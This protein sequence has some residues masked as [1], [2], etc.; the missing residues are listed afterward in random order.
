[1]NRFDR[2]LGILLYLR[3]GRM[4][5]AG[6][7][8]TR[9]E[10]SPRTIYRDVDALAELGVPVYAERGREG[11]LRLMEGYFLPPIMFSTHEATSLLMGL[12]LMRRLRVTPFVPAI[13]T[14]EQKLLAAMP[15][16]LRSVMA[17]LKDMIGFEAIPDDLF[18]I[19]ARQSELPASEVD[20]SEVVSVFLQA[21]FERKIVNIQYRSPYSRQ[22][23]DYRATAQG[24]L[25]DRDRW[26]LVGHIGG[27]QVEQR[28]WRAD[29]VL[30]I[31][32]GSPHEGAA[33]Q[34][35]IS[36]ML[37]RGWLKTA[38]EQWRS[39]APVKIR[40]SAEQASRLKQ[41]W[42]FGFARYDDLLDG[43]VIMTYGED[44]QHYVFNLL[45]WLGPG[46]ELLKPHNWRA[47]LREE[48]RQMVTIY[49]DAVVNIHGSQN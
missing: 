39:E 25:W 37:G 48:L 2:I 6:E 44:N 15:E 34:F 41:D 22:T 18:L 38:M 36:G 46:A 13:E 11:G 4:V 14:A 10:V 19:E 7:L 45:R 29:R 20:E 21:I 16:S 31:R 49:E 35:H 42:Y 43:Q 40:L 32:K 1:M 24:L 9:F 23:K 8:A 28:L 5:S 12:L 26:Y 27:D 3:G 17:N 47:D 33:G 30:T